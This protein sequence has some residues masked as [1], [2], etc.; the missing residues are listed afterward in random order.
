MSAAEAQARLLLAVAV[1]V[2]AVQLLG[3]LFA[4]LR[5]PR[6][7][8]EL[9]AGILLG[10]SLLG[11]VAPSVQGYLFPDQVVG[12]VR[13]IAGLGLVLFVMLVGMEVDSASLRG[14]GRTVLAIGGASVLVPFGLA[15]GFALV[16]HPMFG[17]TVNP[18]GFTVFLGAAMA[19]T[20]LPVLARILQDLGL[21]RTRVGRLSLLCSALN[22]VAAWLLVGTAAALV[23]AG[24]PSAVV[25]TLSLTL[26]FV[27]VMLF[28]VAPLLAKWGRPP[29]WS[30]LVITAACAWV[31]HQIGVHEM[32][33]AFLA[34]VAM[35]RNDGWRD[36]L[37][38]KLEFVVK[39]L[40]MP[41]FFT[42]VGLSTRIG[43]LTAA[44][45]LLAAAAI[46]VATLG[47][48]GGTV[49]AARTSG[50]SWQDSVSL[51]VLMNT[52]GVTEIV[53]LTIGRDLG[54]IT[55]TVF[56]VMVIM[57]LVTTLLAA[58]LLALVGKTRDRPPK[59]PVVTAGTAPP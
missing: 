14:G 35:P 58:P 51:G 43:D 13:G 47:K 56:T 15:V 19:V 26:G 20:A 50:E 39:S 30:V 44:G 55:D 21:E 2:L 9:T 18:V 59:P 12:Q 34:G 36:R 4:R 10:P 37:Q 11:H 46:V 22:D 49:L 17:N 31:S 25:R 6:V 7:L 38:D 52:R 3:W 24:H 41:L 28:V 54:I 33:G 8:G 27:L 1:V 42:V 53:V 29:F 40:L 23:G 32:I 48:F 57:T 45:W 5:Q 16:I